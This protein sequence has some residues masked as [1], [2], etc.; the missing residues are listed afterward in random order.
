[1]RNFLLATAAVACLTASVPASA[2]VGDILR[3]G[4]ESVL[5]GNRGATTEPQLRELNNRIQSAYQRGEISQSQASRLQDELR[6]IAQ[7]ELSYR[8][9]GLNRAE[10]DDLQQRL[11]MVEGRIQQASYDGNRDRRYDDRDGRYGDRDGRYGDR[12]GR[13]D[14]R[15]GGWNENNGR[16]CPPGLAR[17]NNGC[18]PPGQAQRQG[19]RY[20]NEYG[21]VPASYGERY[22]DSDRYYYRYNDGRIYQIDRRTNR[23]VS[24]TTARR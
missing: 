15:D 16:A 13:Y 19:D 14:D 20:S 7:R 10:R 12:D 22:R 2:Q 18:L 24:V 23:I 5:G 21:R 9:G 11:Q 8:S 1:M 4:I 17:K 6:D 3:Q